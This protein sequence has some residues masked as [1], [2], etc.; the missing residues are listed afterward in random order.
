MDTLEG[1]LRSNDA[2]LIIPLL[3]ELKLPS[4]NAQIYLPD[5]VAIEFLANHLRLSVQTVLKSAKIIQLLRYGIIPS[6]QPRKFQKGRDNEGRETIDALSVLASMK[7]GSVTYK[8]I[9]GVLGK[10]NDIQELV[11]VQTWIELPND[12][13]RNLIRTNHITGKELLTLCSSNKALSAKCDNNNGTLFRQLLDDQF[14]ITLPAD[15]NARKKYMTIYHDYDTLKKLLEKIMSW[16]RMLEGSNE[17]LYFPDDVYD[18]LYNT[19]LFEVNLIGTEGG[20][21]LREL[22]SLRTNVEIARRFFGHL[23]IHRLLGQKRD[24]SFY[25]K[26]ENTSELELVEDEAQFYE[27]SSEEFLK[28]LKEWPVNLVR[29]LR[30][31]FEETT[32]D[33]IIERIESGIKGFHD[34]FTIILED[35]DVEELREDGITLSEE[36]IETVKLTN[37][38]INL[39]L[40]IH[41]AVLKG[42]IDA[43]YV[44][45]IDRDNILKIVSHLD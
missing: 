43:S 22:D 2:T 25:A 7:I 23:H 38:E 29:Y 40:K 28:I 14:G 19:S 1:F 18:L 4:S 3:L 13:F 9:D 20:E 37:D 44:I 6:G 15:V 42:T 27:M 32:D 16:T 10:G 24:V 30:S 11:I 33:E 35:N 45:H 41:H 5:D 21:K 26:E 36:G 34:D 39:V 8:V 31:S 17:S 12:V